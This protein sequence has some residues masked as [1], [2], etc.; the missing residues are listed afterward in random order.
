MGAM[1][2]AFIAAVGACDSGSGQEPGQEA[3]RTPTT[4]IPEGTPPVGRFLAVAG[5]QSLDAGLYEIR[6]APLRLERLTETSRMGAVSACA[7]AVVVAAAQQEVG[8]SDTLQ[9]LRA[10]KLVPFEGLGDAKGSAPALTSDCRMAYKAVDRTDPALIDRL[11]IWDPDA[12][13]DTV[14]HSSGELLGLDRGPN[15]QVSVIEGVRGDPG[16][17]VAATAIIIISADRTVRSIPAPAPDLGVLRWAASSRMAI[18]RNDAKSTLFLDPETGARSELPGWR[19][20]AWSPDGT[21][22]LV[23]DSAEYR[24]LGIV[25]STDLS[26]VRALGR[27]EVGVYDLA[28]L[29]A[30][31]TPDQGG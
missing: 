18:G 16:Q 2:L 30:G 5:E 6:F 19:P 25:Q 27:V 17:P 14:V 4:T 31:A 1:A 21:E 26:T 28:W 3:E 24:T 15:G 8:F 13:T 23:A 12:R 20:L 7:S 9:M 29:P 10:G 11:H 22:L